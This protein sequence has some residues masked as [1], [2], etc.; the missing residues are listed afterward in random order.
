MS[1][2]SSD[3]EF[4]KS[5]FISGGRKG[6]TPLLSG[7]RHAGFPRITKSERAAGVIQVSQ[8]LFVE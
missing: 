8:V 7:V 1:V 3:M 6:Q 2:E 4:V 5:I